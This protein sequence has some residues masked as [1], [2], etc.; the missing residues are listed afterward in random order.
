M[1]ATRSL[2]LIT[3]MLA[4]PAAALGS[5]SVIRIDPATGAQTVLASGAPLSKL[6][7]IVVNDSGTIYVT[8]RA[9]IFSLTA[10]AFAVTPVVSD[11]S[12][13]GGLVAV[14]S[15]LYGFGGDIV[16]SIETS[17]PFAQR[18]VTD[19]GVYDE[20]TVGPQFGALAGS[21]L[22]TTTYSSC[23]SVEGGPG[24]VVAVDV[25]TG[26]QTWVRSFS[27]GGLQGIA[28]A[29]D[30]TL[31]IAESASDEGPARIARL[32]PANDALSNVA[33]GGA[34][35]DP[36][37][38]ALDASGRLLVADASSGVLAVSTTN[39][40]QSTL[41]SGPALGGVNGVA[42]D[43]RGNIYVTAPGAPPVLKVSAKSR[44][45]SAAG[46]RFKASCKPRCEFGYSADVQ[47]K[48]IDR[49]SDS[50]GIAT[51]GSTR[52][53][54]A[55]MGKLMRRDIAREL[56]RHRTVR[57]KLTAYA[58]DVDGDQVGKTVGLTVRLTR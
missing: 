23:E 30:G 1:F 43:A 36:R 16:R 17:A 33:S 26:R 44:R 3:V 15:S 19:G 28:L 58:R 8:D 41:A 50:G 51:V 47:A 56:A 49:Y 45:L 2:A 11:D 24:Q 52:T 25:A 14:G 40:A 35:K 4:F 39:G 10:P 7:G 13:W 53:L 12:Y 31:L 18:V 27:C 22:Y 9:G 32:N 48:G 55:R 5:P 42:L 34:I 46:F 37:G 21:T 54:T 57:I 29:P 38:I 20:T 6:G